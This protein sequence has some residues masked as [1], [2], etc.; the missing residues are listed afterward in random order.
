M[1]KIR[2]HGNSHVRTDHYSPFR[3]KYSVS[4]QT[5]AVLKIA[6]YMKKIRGYFVFLC[7]R[8]LIVIL[9]INYTS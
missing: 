5:A 8:I 3:S 7:Q 9:L 4:Y 2:L 6:T 1:R